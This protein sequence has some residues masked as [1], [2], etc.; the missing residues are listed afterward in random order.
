MGEGQKRISLIDKATDLL[1]AS[2]ENLT[3]ALAL[4]LTGWF[5]AKFV[6]DG[7]GK[8][9]D[10]KENYDSINQLEEAKSSFFAGSVV[11]FLA[12][13]SLVFF[14][15]QN[16]NRQYFASVA[17]ENIDDL[18]DDIV[19]SI[20]SAF[21]FKVTDT[22][23]ELTPGGWLVEVGDM[24]SVYQKIRES[25]MKAVSAKMPM[26]DFLKVLKTEI[27]GDE[28]ISGLVKSHFKTIAN[29]VYS[30][31]DRMNAYKFAIQLGLR[32]A[33]Y[34]GGLIDHSRPFCIERNGQVFTFDEIEKFGTAEDTYGGYSDKATGDFNGKPDFD[35]DPFFD[36]GGH[37]CRHAYNY[38]SDRLAIHL[39]PEL[40]EV[41][42]KTKKPVNA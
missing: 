42:A 31:F 16:L 5:T 6:L 36:Q 27:Q 39:R 9:E 22:D 21:G 11:P 2:V 26:T 17:E 25:A 40:K 35:Y 13:I 29:N 34:E 3:A 24:K 37:N 1:H 10:S 14:N 30:E 7:D 4:F 15:I 32:A 18:A 41:F 38:I 23:I 12:G 8:I 20:S 28:T 33:I 19:E